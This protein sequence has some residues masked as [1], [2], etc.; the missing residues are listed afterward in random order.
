MPGL[1]FLITRS[2]FAA[3]A[4]R[5]GDMLG[6]IS[7]L[8][9]ASHCVRGQNPVSAVRTTEAPA[10]QAT[11][12]SSLSTNL[13]AIYQPQ[14]GGA[15]F[16]SNEPPIVP[17]EDEL[18]QLRHAAPQ[19]LQQSLA[20]P[21]TTELLRY[22]GR[23]PAATREHAMNAIQQVISSSFLPKGM[24]EHLIPLSRWAVLYEDWR[25]HGGIDVFLTKFQANGFTAVVMESQNHI[26]VVARELKGDRSRE[27]AGMQQLVQHYADVL[28][29][30]SLKPV[31][32]QSLQLFRTSLAPLYI[33]GYYTPKID[34]LT[35]DSS[36]ADLVTTAGGQPNEQST[37][38]RA[39]AVRFFCN[40]EFTA[41]ML[42]KPVKTGELKNPFD[43]R[44]EPLNLAQGE[45][46][47]F[48]EEQSPA[49]RP[50]LPDA[51]ELRR[52][53]VR[54]Y[55][56]SFFYD[57]DG[58]ALTDRIPVQDLERE[59]T[60]LS[61]EQKLD[62]ARRKIIDENYASG[63]AAFAAGETTPALEAWTRI[64]QYEPENARASILL[65]VAIKQRARVAYNGNTETARRAEP[66]IQ[67]ALDQIA[68]QQ[69]LLSLR[70]QQEGM[71]LTKERYIQD[72]RTRAIDFFSEGAYAES[73]REW[74]KLLDVDPGNANALLFKEICET[75]IKQAARSRPRATPAATFPAAAT[76]ARLTPAAAAKK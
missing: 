59:F 39:T 29:R 13:P 10:G 41:F 11:P 26:I 32:A 61:R 42:L 33:Y 3:K 46:I 70:Q 37:S 24:Q 5:R 27:F 47:P 4:T 69:T 36:T 19:W 45:Q 31:N 72:Y 73:L 25:K 18:Y 65:Q 23:E 30:E 8:L 67:Q 2:R 44:F 56:G 51:E 66:A 6:L 9:L 15:R 48:W 22:L 7:C 52:R 55:L 35:G 63:M 76:P 58:N 74:N 28:L 71:D 49:A 1:G 38:A 62:I 54:E 57:Q 50:D 75:K 16:N 68:R 64:L 12:S 20:F 21:S 17:N 14:E 53:Q 34:T 43:P 40:G 60:E